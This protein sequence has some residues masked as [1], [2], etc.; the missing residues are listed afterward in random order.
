MRGLYLIWLGPHRFGKPLSIAWAVSL[1][2]NDFTRVA[3]RTLDG[4]VTHLMSMSDA[5]LVLTVWQT[6]L[7]C[8]CM[9]GANTLIH[10]L[11][12]Y[13][14]AIG[15]GVFKIYAGDGALQDHDMVKTSIRLAICHGYDWVVPLRHDDEIRLDTLEFA[16]R[17]QEV[18]GSHPGVIWE[19]HVHGRRSSTWA[20]LPMTAGFLFFVQVANV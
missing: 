15:S 9:D 3:Q 19:D 6:E 16:S 5:C 14:S 17:M 10:L 1:N 8:S 2:I 18:R 12:L 7:D 13:R 11:K 20:I 4:N